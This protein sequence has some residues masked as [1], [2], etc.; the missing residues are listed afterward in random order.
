[1]E[2]PQQRLSIVY[3]SDGNDIHRMNMSVFTIRKY[4]GAN[5]DIYLLTESD[6][7]PDDPDVTIINPHDVLTDVGLH[8]R[9]WNRSWPFATLY[10]LAIPL[11]PAFAKV[12]RVLYLDCDV[13]CESSEC[14]GLAEMNLHGYEILGA[15]DH[16]SKLFR[17]IDLIEQELCD[18]GK[19]E[20]WDRLWRV[21]GTRARTYINAG[22]SLWNLD[23]IRNNGLPWYVKR[24]QWFWEAETRGRFYMLDQDFL[25]LMM[26][27]NAGLNKRFNWFAE[28]PGVRDC[29]FRHYVAGTKGLMEPA[30]SARGWS[31]PGTKV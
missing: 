29:V 9:G 6:R 27:T 28:H 3:A 24:L 15:F 1:M 31:R 17:N 11:L 20:M 14:L 2:Y 25:N 16:E 10:R 23:A 4:L 5:A 21:S 18:D 26:D 13:I 22:V 19:K 30:V 12:S 7:R 8:P